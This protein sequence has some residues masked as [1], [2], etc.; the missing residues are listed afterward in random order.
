MAK[1]LAYQPFIDL[2]SLAEQWAGSSGGKKQSPFQIA[3]KWAYTELQLETPLIRGSSS[4]MILACLCSFAN[5]ACSQLISRKNKSEH[6]LAMPPF[7]DWLFCSS[8]VLYHRFQ[9]MGLP[10]NGVIN[11]FDC[12]YPH[13]MR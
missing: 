4:L 7:Q 5:L 2:H 3:L 12:D 6:R 9:K 8:Y 11:L 13:P 10:L 1:L